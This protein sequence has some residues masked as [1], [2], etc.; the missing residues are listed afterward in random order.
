MLGDCCKLGD[1]CYLGGFKSDTDLLFACSVVIGGFASLGVVT[2]PRMAV[3]PQ[4]TICKP[5]GKSFNYFN[6]LVLKLK[7]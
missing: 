2:R 5:F 1:E 6:V 7:V 4:A 3:E